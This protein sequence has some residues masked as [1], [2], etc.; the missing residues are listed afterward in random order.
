MELVKIKASDYELEESKANELTA[1]LNVTLKE[2]KLLIDEFDALSKLE[3]NKENIPKFKELRLRIVKNRTLGIDKWHK[4][5]KNYFLKGGQFV[6]AIKRKETAVNE[7]MEE[8]LMGAEDHFENIEKERLTKLQGDRATKLSKYM[9]DAHERNLAGMDEDVW[10]AYFSTKKKEYEDMLAAEKKAEEDRIA[11]E[12][13]EADERERIGKE[14][15]QLK[16]EAEEKERL[17]KIESEKREKA[18]KERLEKEAKERKKAEEKAQ[19]ERDVYEKKLKAEREEKEKAE[20]ELKAKAEAERK[21]AEEKEAKFQAELNKGDEEKVNDLINDL[22][23]LKSKY[24]FQSDKN[25]AMYA[26]VRQLIDKII[27]H[28][29]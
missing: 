17:A 12:K 1:G 10:N 8:K 3:V 20:A 5:A 25:T 24:V 9:E 2:R 27:N 15:I 19:R 26:V 11:K 7:S 23:V 28:I 6:D 13:A 29:Q 14:N 16:K 21:E 18:E 22:S 4:A